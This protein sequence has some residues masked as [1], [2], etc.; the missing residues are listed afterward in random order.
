MAA[1]ST[2]A[3]RFDPQEKLLEMELTEAHQTFFKKEYTLST[4]I[5]FSVGNCRFEVQPGSFIDLDYPEAWKAHK[6]CFHLKKKGSMAV[7]YALIPEQENELPP[8]PSTPVRDTTTLY[9]SFEQP[10]PYGI[11]IKRLS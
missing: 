1:L 4:P 10:L 9:F 11:T 7:G 5:E 3:L 8:T 6:L 2:Q